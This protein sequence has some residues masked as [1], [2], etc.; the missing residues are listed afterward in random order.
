MLHCTVLHRDAASECINN[1]FDRK[2]RRARSLRRRGISVR[3]LH[4]NWHQ[5]L[6]PCPP[7]NRHESLLP[8]YTAKAANHLLST[9]TRATIS[10]Q[11]LRTCFFNANSRVLLAAKDTASPRRY[12]SSLVATQPPFSGPDACQ[13]KLIVEWKTCKGRP[14]AKFPIRDGESLLDAARRKGVQLEGICSSPPSCL[15]SLVQ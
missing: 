14:V 12:T 7:S 9:M 10:R 2:M 15:M 5:V 6:E 13:E 4:V 1:A 11:R 3:S 8:A